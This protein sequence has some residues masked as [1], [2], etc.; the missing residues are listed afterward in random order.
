MN[1]LDIVIVNWNSGEQLRQCLASIVKADRNGFTLSHV[2]IVDNASQDDSLSRVEQYNLPLRIIHNHKN[3]GFAVACNQGA[4][5]SRADYLLFLNP[6]TRLFLDS[7]SRPIHLMQQPGN[8]KIG[9]CGIQFIDDHGE[10]S[11]TCARFPTPFMFFLK[12]L[13]LSRL[14]PAWF[15]SY[16]MTE[17]DHGNS[18]KVDQ[19]MGAFFLIKRLLFESLGGFDEQFFVYFEDVDFSLRARNIGWFSYYL[20]DAQAYHKG[21][22]TSEWVKATRLFYSLQSRI[23]YGYKHFDCWSASMLM[24]GTLILEPFARLVLAILSCSHLQAV[25]TLKGYSMLLREMPELFRNR[26]GYNR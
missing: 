9:I 4:R 6:D 5:G 24:L 16:T 25:E 7:L 10:I 2:Y 19:V 1:T 12:M 23:L 17:W 20:A 15:P 26:M 14:F 18:R 3:K 11:R 13:G 22:G 8:E 21:G